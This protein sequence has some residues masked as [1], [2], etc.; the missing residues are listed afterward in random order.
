MTALLLLFLGASGNLFTVEA[1]GAASYTVG[2]PRAVLGRSV[3][4]ISLF[5]RN[6]PGVVGIERL[7]EDL[8]LYRT[9]KEIPLAGPME[10][11]FRIRRSS[12]GDTLTVYRSEDPADPN[13]MSCTVRVKALDE[14]RTSVSIALRIRLSRSRPWEIHWLAPVMGEDFIS[15]QMQ[16]DLEEM[17]AEFVESS[18][19]ELHARFPAPGGVSDVGK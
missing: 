5:E 19:R 15:A 17:L 3:D 7:G 9:R 16:E 10:T 4:D 12:W 1:T 2:V 8:F 14:Q 11:I 13:Y 6:M 18:N